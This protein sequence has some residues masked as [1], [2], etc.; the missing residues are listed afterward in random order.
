MRTTASRRLSR[1]SYFS[2]SDSSGRMARNR[3]RDPLRQLQ[4][5]RRRSTPDRRREVRSPRQ[6]VVAAARPDP[7]AARPL[8]LYASYS[9]SYLP[10]SGD[11]F[12]GLTDITEGLKPERF[13]NYEVG[14]KWKFVDGLL[15]TAAV[16][17]L[18]R[19]N[20]RAIDPNDPTRTVLTGAQ[21]SRGIE[22]G[23][24]AASAAAGKSRPVTRCRRPRSRRPRLPRPRAA[25]CRWCRVTASRSGTAT[26]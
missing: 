21:R 22:L 15:A 1:P 11:Q 4:H 16:Y 18:D 6:S 2:G 14:A 12:S 5:Q 3:R 24:R 10:Q 19:S 13:D 26:T 20:T 8:S 7:E 23:L 25:K 17:R 9:R